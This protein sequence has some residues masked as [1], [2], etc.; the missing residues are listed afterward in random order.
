MKLTSILLFTLKI[1]SASATVVGF[2]CSN[3]LDSHLDIIQKL[4]QWLITYKRA[5]QKS[6]AIMIDNSLE[7]DQIK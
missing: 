5:K 3:S 7:H 2:K 1:T 4:L 6:M